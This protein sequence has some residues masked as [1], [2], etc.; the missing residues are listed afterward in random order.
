VSVEEYDD[1]IRGQVEMVQMTRDEV[2]TIILGGTIIAGREMNEEEIASTVGSARLFVALGRLVTG[3][4]EGKLMML[5]TDGEM[6][7]AEATEE[8]RQ[9][10]GSGIAEKIDDW[11]GLVAN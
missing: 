8:Y 5:V 10:A 1:F 9:C 2:S 7:I 11:L 6:T 4:V 3:I